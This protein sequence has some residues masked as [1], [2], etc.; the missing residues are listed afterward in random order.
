MTQQAAARTWRVPLS[1]LS[2]LER[3]EVR[4]YRPQTLARFDAVL[5]RPAWELYV[6]GV[7]M[8]DLDE[9]ITRQD[10]MAAELTAMRAALEALTPVPH[11]R[12]YSHLLELLDEL[13]PHEVTQVEHFAQYLI[14]QRAE[15][16]A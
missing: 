1:V 11:T 16:G 3:G 10:T 12:R 6:G 8:V 9:L 5:G 4:A 7:V 13:G 14:A 15:E 2:A